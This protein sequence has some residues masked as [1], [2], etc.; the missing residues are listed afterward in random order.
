MCEDGF[1]LE[2]DLCVDE[3]TGAFFEDIANGVC[4]AC[5]TGCLDC[6]DQDSCNTC[7]EAFSINSDNVC[8][9]C[10]INC[11]VCESSMCV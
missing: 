1:Y 2:D 9:G 6:T 10:D 4:S 5:S 11:E 8:D 3:C 7:E